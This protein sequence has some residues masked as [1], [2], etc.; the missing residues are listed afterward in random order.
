MTV[1]PTPNPPKQKEH[2]KCPTKSIQK[3][4]TTYFVWVEIIPD[5]VKTSRPSIFKPLLLQLERFLCKEQWSQFQVHVQQTCHECLRQR[6]NFTAFESLV[7]I[8][9]YT[10]A[11][12]CSGVSG[13]TYQGLIKSRSILHLNHS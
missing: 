12:S 13:T 1:S 4:V 6:P 9:Q 7:N 3:L 8:A 2:E 10:K 5:F 11:P